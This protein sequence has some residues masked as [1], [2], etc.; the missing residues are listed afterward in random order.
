[1][2]EKKREDKDKTE[3]KERED[4]DRAEQKERE[5]QD[6]EE[7]RLYKEADIEITRLNAEADT[8]TS[9]KVKSSDIAREFISK[10]TKLSPFFESHGDPMDAY[11]HR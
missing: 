4:K 7:R 11:S 8:S 6:R 2:K 3:W 1:M 5:Y 9:S 10:L